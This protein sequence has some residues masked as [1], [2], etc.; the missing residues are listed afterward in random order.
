MTGGG[1]GSGSSG[2]TGS[3]GG[4]GS[5]IGMGA[6]GDGGGS[7][8]SSRMTFLC[9]YPRDHKPG[10]GRH[11]WGGATGTPDRAHLTREA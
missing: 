4:S 5:G 3:G 6:S 2:G 1:T 11:R 10:S 8:V 7:G 9:P